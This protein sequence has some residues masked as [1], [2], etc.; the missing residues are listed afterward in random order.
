MHVDSLMVFYS[1]TS[2]CSC[3][4][5]GFC[6][7]ACVFSVHKSLRKVFPACTQ[8]MAYVRVNFLHLS[9]KGTF[10]PFSYPFHFFLSY[11]E[12]FA[13]IEKDS[14]SEWVS[15]ALCLHTLKCTFEYLWWVYVCATT[16]SSRCCVFDVVVVVA[17]ASRCPISCRL[18]KMPPTI[19]PRK[20]RRQMEIF[21]GSFLKNGR[22]KHFL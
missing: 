19:R 12:N 11:L 9:V 4:F 3:G 2:S 15:S 8:C 7:F 22:C 5:C 20:N 1:V 16:S 6:A 17:V 13:H 21:I 14:L 18:L 10:L